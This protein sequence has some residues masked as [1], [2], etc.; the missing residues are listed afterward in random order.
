MPGS[1]WDMGAPPQSAPPAYHQDG[2]GTQR[3]SMWD[4]GQP[5]HSQPSQPSQS[6]WDQGAPRSAGLTSNAQPMHR[7]AAV[8]PRPTQAPLMGPQGP[9]TGNIKKGTV[10]SYSVVKGFGFILTPDIPQDI[11]FG[12]DSLQADLRT[13]DVAGTQVTFELI[14]AP[15][16]KPQARNLRPI[17]NAPPT[18]AQMYGAPEAGGSN[19]DGRAG[20]EQPR[21]MGLAGGCPQVQAQGCWPGKGMV[22]Q[23][24]MNPM[25]MGMGC[26]PGKGGGCINP[27]FLGKPGFPPIPAGAACFARP[28]FPMMPNQMPGQ[29]MPGMMMRPGMPGAGMMRPGMPGVGMMGQQ[30]MMNGKGPM[31]NRARDWS[32]H[33][34]S[35][36]IRSAIKPASEAGSGKGQGRQSKSSSRSRSRSRSRSSSSS[37]S[38]SR[39]RSRKKKKQKKKKHKKKKGRSSSTISSSSSGKDKDK[40]GDTGGD[41]ADK[42]AASGENP[43]VQKAKMEALAKLRE[44]QAVEPKEERSKQF[45]AL[46]REWHPDKN[47]EKTEVATAVFQFLQKGKNLL[48]LK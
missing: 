5:G 17:G 36:A 35:R 9:L 34:G 8:A 48:N 13:S 1:M 30:G 19:V 38:R 10:K 40:N 33:A 15:D 7:P 23:S 6:M 11:Y 18:A 25:G 31:Q 4:Q 28:S 44:M 24:P 20:M 26:F 27:A 14:R 21:P 42:A 47:P 3:T 32:P 39:S 29:T 22:G 16:G 12:R 2:L 37:K 45:R 43:E 41:D 46:L